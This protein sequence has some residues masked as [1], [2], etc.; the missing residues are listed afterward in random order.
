MYRWVDHT[1]E[2]ELEIEAGS[3]VEVFGDA[4]G[5]LAELLGVQEQ[6]DERRTLTVSGADRAA[7]LAAWLEELVFLAE[8]AT[9]STAGCGCSRCRS[10]SM[11]WAAAESSWCTRYPGAF[12]SVQGARAP[13]R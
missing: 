10:S 7:L 12:R 6:G 3:E 4:L 2:V 8:S 11:G 9:T 13:V 1:G 5:A